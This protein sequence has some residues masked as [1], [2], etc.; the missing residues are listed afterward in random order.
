M[1]ITVLADH[2]ETESFC[3]EFGLS[4]L[5]RDHGKSILFDTGAGKA[6]T[7]NLR[8]LNIPA[9][10]ISEVILSHGHYDHTGGLAGLKPKLIHSCPNITASHFSRHEDGS[11]H[12]LTMPRE[13]QEVLETT[14]LHLI[15]DFQEIAEGLY[16]TGPIPRISGEDCGGDFYHD[17][18]CT[19]PDTIQDEQA[20]LSADGI[21]I[22]GCCHAGILNTLMY[23]REKHPEIRIQ[24]IAGGLHLLHANKERLERTA[25]FFRETGITTLCLLH[26]TGTDAIEFLKTALPECKIISPRPGETFSL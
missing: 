20:L 21:L 13:S 8:H 22:T 4:L 11:M 19:R 6:L 14:D 26:C 16:L 2:Q 25:D 23:C 24:K 3:S 15:A 18:T 1:E 5:I 12:R 7:Q 10:S 17:E 9:E